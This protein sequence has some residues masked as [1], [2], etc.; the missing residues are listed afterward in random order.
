M[1]FKLS[2]PVWKITNIKPVQKLVLLALVDHACDDCGFC[3]PGM[4]HLAVK[5]GLGSTA[6]AAAIK[7]LAESPEGL[8]RI[9]AYPQGGRGRATEY[10]VLPGVIKLST[11]P[12][13]KCLFRMQYP[14]PDGGFDKS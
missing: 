13:G 1:S 2:V 11:A 10:V 9:H 7:A 4:R 8:L 14:P 3:W 12:C 5:T 6:I